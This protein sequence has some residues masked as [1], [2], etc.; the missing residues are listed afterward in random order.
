MNAAGVQPARLTA[1][2][3]T[4]PKE[5]IAE[6]MKLTSR[7]RGE[8]SNSQARASALEKCD[9]TATL[10]DEHPG[11]VTSRLVTRRTRGTFHRSDCYETEILP[12]RF[13]KD[14]RA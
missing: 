1:S 6:D 5:R 14:A 10:G 4:D 2:K 11:R 12:H 9:E 13:C 3:I 7:H 8:P